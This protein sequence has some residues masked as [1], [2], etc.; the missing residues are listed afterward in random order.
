MVPSV[1]ALKRV[2]NTAQLAEK[3]EQAPKVEMELWT[4]FRSEFNMTGKECYH[5]NWTE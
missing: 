3:S 1:K 5:L 2:S 4:D